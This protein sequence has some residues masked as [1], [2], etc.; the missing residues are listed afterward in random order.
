MLAEREGFIRTFIDEGPPMAVLLS[1][2]LAQGRMPNYTGKLL[3]AW[4][5]EKQQTPDQ[6]APRTEGVLAEPLS[7]RELEVLR[8]IAQGPTPEEP[9]RDEPP[10]N[11]LS[12]IKEVRS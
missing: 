12:A 11:P 7:Q 2:A 3:A 5:A 4:E 1:D 9:Q 8:L 10:G 6:L